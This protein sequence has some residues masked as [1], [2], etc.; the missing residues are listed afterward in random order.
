MR[1]LIKEDFTQVAIGEYQT[2]S[3]WI[4]V[5]MFMLV[6]SHYDYPAAILV[7]ILYG[8]YLVKTKNLIGTM[9]AHGVTNLLLAIFILYTGKY[10][11]W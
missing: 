10:Y 1:Y 9:I 11:Y 5:L 7:G 4:T 8:F 2:K 6:H 3:F